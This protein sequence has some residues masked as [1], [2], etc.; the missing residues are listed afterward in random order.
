MQTMRDPIVPNISK[1]PF[2]L[3]DALLLALAALIVSRSGS[4]LQTW[5]IIAC[6]VC[7]A[8]GAWL[9]A[10]PFIAE[11]HAT[12][13]MAETA[14]LTTAVAQIQ[15]V[16]QLAAQIGYATSQWQVVRE[17]AD[18][19]AATARDIAQNIA[20]EA[21]SFT[22][23]LQ[24]AND[25]EKATLR[26]EVEKLRR[27]ENEWLQVLVRIL[28]HVYALHQ[29]ALRSRQPAVIEQLGKFR[30]AVYDTARR[31]GLVPFEAAASEAFDEK[32]H[33][34]VD[35]HAKPLADATVA[36]TIATGYTFQ[37]RL[38]RPALVRL[39]GEPPLFPEASD[40]LPDSEETPSPA[41][42]QLP[43]ETKA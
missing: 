16:Q 17:A 27:A 9:A 23:F 20:S 8:A 21:R 36:E 19:T 39:D 33:Q 26:L 1:W 7:T 4:P 14:G 5:E 31:L 35:G 29:A 12:V 42:S 38:V 30:S 10:Y 11:H 37:G 32:R 24:R 6:V 43:L 15:N 22:E 18:K 41:Q 3:G 40:K 28:D 25:S 34:L 2:L 13:R